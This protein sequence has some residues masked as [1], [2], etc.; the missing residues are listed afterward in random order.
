[1]S[2]GGFGLSAGNAEDQFDELSGYFPWIEAGAKTRHDGL[3]IRESIMLNYPIVQVA[4]HVSDSVKAAEKMAKLYGA[5]PFFLNERI[6][7]EWGIH[8]G[9]E[10]KFLHTSA[11][12]QWGSVMLE[13][14]QQD[15]EGPSPFRDM[16]APGEEGIHH[17]AMIVDSMASAYADCEAAGYEIAAKAMTLGG[18]EFA[19]VDTVS[20]LGHMIEIYERSVGLLGFYEMVR[21]ASIDWDG[22]NL[23]RRLGR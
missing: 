20:E 3:I 21:L 5:G 22:S 15:E 11:F 8:R 13:L 12:G 6:E 16:Y 17:T 2:L 1:M 14:L 7:L 19:F 10:Q 9:R 4:Y 18:A 23:I